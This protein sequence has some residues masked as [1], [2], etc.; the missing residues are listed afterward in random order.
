MSQ[1][2]PYLRISPLAAAIQ[3]SATLAAGAKARQLKA[4]G[5]QVF[6]FSLGEPDFPT[7]EHICRAAFKAM[8]EGQTHYTP[9]SGTAEV[10]TAIARLYEKTYG[11]RVSAEQVI[12]SNGAKHSIATTL[13]A[14]CGPGDEVIIPSPYWVSY[15]DLVQ[16]SGATAVLVPTAHENAFKMTPAQLRNAMTPRSRLLMLNSPGN[17]TG[18]VYSRQELEALADVVLESRIAVLSDEIYER[19]VYGDARTTCFA[20]LRPGLAERTVTVSGVSKSYAMTGWRIGWTVGPLP[21]I[22]A[23]GNIQSQQTGCPN[24]ISQVATVAALEGDQDCVEKMRRE[25]EARRDLVCRRLAALPGIVCP[26]PGGA[27]YA[28]FNVAAHFGRTLGGHKVTDGATFC[29]AALESAH[30]NVVPGSAFGA[31]GYVRLSFATS[32][33]QL[34][35]G[36]DQLERFLTR[37]A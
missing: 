4:E 22:K 37:G 2:P 11:L 1:T 27:F 21:V 28:F 31:E 24:S 30:V 17:P 3:P 13:T 35:G 15:S 12:V 33:E 10:R 6:D 9:A 36:L 18:T 34:N 23:M 26:V 29:Q 32:R 14:M 20:T 5:I 8:Q 16:M 7:P 25:F 19:L